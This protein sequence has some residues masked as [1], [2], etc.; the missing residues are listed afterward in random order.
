MLWLT[1][2]YILPGKGDVLVCSERE[3]SDLF[4]ATLGGLGQFGII[5]SARIAL[6]PAPQRV[7]FLRTS[8]SALL[9]A[10]VRVRRAPFQA[11]AS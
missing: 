1:L 4:H 7:I 2:R 5:T 3:H 10:F 11:L 9:R 8:F 6:E